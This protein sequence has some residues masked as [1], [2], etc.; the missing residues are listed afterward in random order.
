MKKENWNEISSTEYKIDLTASLSLIAKKLG[1]ETHTAWILEM[2]VEDKYRLNS[3]ESWIKYYLLKC[4]G[5]VFPCF[6]CLSIDV[7]EFFDSMSGV[8]KSELACLG[9]W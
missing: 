3:T 1:E 5:T 6:S 8:D 2:N 7:E 4:V 9:Q